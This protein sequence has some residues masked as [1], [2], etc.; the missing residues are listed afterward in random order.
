[1]Q[2]PELF[3]KLNQALSQHPQV[4]AAYVLGS[5]I[6]NR[7]RPGSDFDLAVVVNHKNSPDE[8]ILYASIQPLE[9]PHNL[10]LSVVDKTSSPLFLF[11]IVSRGQKIYQRSSTD[12]AKFEAFV[13]HR[14]YDTQHLR[15]IYHSYLPEKFYAHR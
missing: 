9:F 6:E 1:M 8:K 2:L 10:D 12:T 4:I 7:A 15:N 5:V 14:Y 11:Q 3:L 13:L